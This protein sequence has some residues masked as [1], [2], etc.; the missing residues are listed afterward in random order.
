MLAFSRMYSS[1]R[2]KWKAQ[3]RKHEVISSGHQE[4]AKVS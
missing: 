1:E 3:A 2:A 4:R